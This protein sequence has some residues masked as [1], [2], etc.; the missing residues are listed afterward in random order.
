M[1]LQ[2]KKLCNYKKK[3]L[4]YICIEMSF[5]SG[6]VLLERLTWPRSVT[7]NMYIVLY[8]TWPNCW[9]FWISVGEF[10]SVCWLLFIDIIYSYTH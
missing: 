10:V 4:T 9:G 3:K 8:S 2:K 1:Q 6:D 5:R 7:I